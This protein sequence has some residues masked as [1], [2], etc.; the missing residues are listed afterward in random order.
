[1]PLRW[2]TWQAPPRV[3]RA[4]DG[5]VFAAYTAA[6]SVGV[7]HHEPWA[8]EAQA[9]LIARDMPFW[10]MLLSEMHYEVSPGLWHAL[11]W[12]AQHWFH[13]PYAA[14][15]WIGAAFAIAGAA[16]LI[17]AAPFPRIVRYLMASSYVVV[18]QYA[19]ISRPYSM[20]L[21][22]GAAAAIF[23]R[24]RE[25][26]A[27]AV[28]LVLLC[29]GSLHG[30]ILAG[31][32]AFAALWR[33][34]FQW[35]T[36]DHPARVRHWQ[37]LAIVSA[38]FVLVVL[39]AYPPPDLAAYSHR[40]GGGMEKLL[41]TL[42]GVLIEPW[43]A[44]AALLII[45]FAW[46][47]EL[48]MLVAGVGGMLAF[49]SFAYGGP[50]HEGTIVIAII[51]ALWMAWPHP[52]DAKPRWFRPAATLVLGLMFGVQTYWA[53]DSWRNDYRLP[54]SGAADAARYLRSVNADPAQTCGLGFGITALHPYFPAGH[55][56]N[57]PY[58][59]MHQSKSVESTIDRPD[60][61]ECPAYLVLVEWSS[62]PDPNGLLPKH[63]FNLVHTSPG[64][65]FFKEFYWAQQ[66]YLIYRRAP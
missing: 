22:F 29:G 24:R 50:H 51:V 25:P 41:D 40:P 47:R 19:V 16:L 33:A 26:I 27:L 61:S 54:Y 34:F 44:A 66:T 11:L 43:Y 23:Y 21:V 46:R 60:F 49:H 3:L 7:M 39:L 52:E 56:A 45:F 32:I 12:V 48:P 55:L 28:S 37:A 42:N 14:L 35:K 10:K 38:A 9:W 15:G 1:M 17:F 30:A 57:W 20:L 4:L 58:A 8:D 62:N 6:V 13:A 65:M 64:H 63:G 5:A 36:L 53:V 31:G 2:P 59:Y 18:Y